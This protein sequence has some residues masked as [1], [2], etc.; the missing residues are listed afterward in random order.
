MDRAKI[1]DKRDKLK[2]LLEMYE[3]GKMSHLE[4]DDSGDLTRDTTPERCA[5]LKRDITEL[6]RQLSELSG[7]AST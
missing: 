2:E 4:A 7:R 3:T 1:Q 5:V 6:D